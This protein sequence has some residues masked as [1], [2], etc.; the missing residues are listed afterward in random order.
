[1]CTYLKEIFHNTAL[2]FGQDSLHSF[3]GHVINNFELC[4]KFPDK[5]HDEQQ[6]H[7]YYVLK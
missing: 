6:Q 2:L 7:Y 3:D 4:N 1:M 5:M